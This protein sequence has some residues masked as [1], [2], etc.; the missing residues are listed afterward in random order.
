M[1]DRTIEDVKRLLPD[2]DFERNIVASFSGLTAR[3]DRADFIIEASE[4]LPTFVNA[5]IV[6]PGITCS[7]AIGKRV[8]EVLRDNGLVLRKRTDFNPYRKRIPSL[9]EASPEDIQ[10]L[11]NQD[12]RYGNV[13]CR[14]ETVTEGEIVEAIKRGATTLDGVKFRTRAGLGRCQSNFCGAKVTDILAREQGK[15]FGAITKKGHNSHYINLED[16]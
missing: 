9:R 16:S 5:A 6:P 4:N 10:E 13:V 11:L 14:C 3:N 2:V 15:S 8:V 12:P 1:I 7:P